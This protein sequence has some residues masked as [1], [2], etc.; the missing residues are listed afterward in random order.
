MR[1]FNAGNL[2][3][4]L[5]CASSLA[6]AEPLTLDE[7]E[8]LALQHSPAFAASKKQVEA[9]ASVPSQVGSLPDPKIS[10]GALN[11]PVDSMSLTKADMTQIQIGISQE[12]PF[13]GKL[14]LKK[15]I[16]EELAK[17]SASNTEGFRL[18]L[19]RNVRIYWWN[20]VYLDKALSIIKDN[21]TLLR[22]LVQ[23]SGAKYSTGKGLQQDVLLAQLELSQLL[24]RELALKAERSQNVSAINALM[25]RLVTTPIEIPNE[26]PSLVKELPSAER[27]SQFAHDNHPMI[28]GLKRKES[29]AE[30]GVSLAEK[31]YYPDFSLGAAY[32]FRQGVSPATG[33]RRSDLAS[34][35]LTM[36]LPIYTDSKQDKGLEQRKAEKAKVQY[37]LQDALLMIDSEIDALLSNLKSTRDQLLLFETGIIPQARQTTASMLAGYQVNKVDF[38]NLVRAQLLEFNNDIQYWK[39]KTKAAQDEARLATSAGME[40]LNK[41]GMNNE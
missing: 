11:L 31:D 28:I 12:I 17:A 14:S 6:V 25:G 37:E 1:L 32:G 30:Y 16:A 22:N 21:Q 27:L 2:L 26:L 36:S 34:V 15:Q 20:I 3:L 5:F 10:M 8:R 33:M 13:P 29:A 24:D 23:V 38:L 40:S 41:D 4:L 9:M 7:A 39:L 19:I 18:L 35:M